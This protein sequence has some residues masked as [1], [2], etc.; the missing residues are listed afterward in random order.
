MTEDEEMLGKI[1]ERLG[2]LVVEASR[3]ALRRLILHVRP[4]EAKE[5]VRILRDEIGCR[6]LSGINGFD[7]GDAIEVM[8]H[9]SRGG[10]VVSVHAP[11]PRSSLRIATVTDLLP[12]ANLYE[13]EVR[14]LFG[15]EFDGHPD[16]RRLMLYEGWPEGQHPLRKDWKPKAQGGDKRA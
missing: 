1:K 16:P 13:R 15:V 12:S 6:H 14:D 10:C 9:M 4:E 11:L 7:T 3:N 2:P 5:V 8:Y